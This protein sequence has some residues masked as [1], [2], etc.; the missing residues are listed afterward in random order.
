MMI[1]LAYKL[2]KAMP[3][4]CSVSVPVLGQEPGQEAVSV[5]EQEKS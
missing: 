5:L 1:W 4:L 3:W 2:I